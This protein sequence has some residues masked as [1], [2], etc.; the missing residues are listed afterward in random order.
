MQR[1][2]HAA[3]LAAVTLVGLLSCTPRRTGSG[4]DPFAGGASRSRSGVRE[5]RVR[6]EVNC[7]GCRIQ[8]WVGPGAADAGAD[9]LWSQQFT[10]TPLQPT[11][12]RVLATPREGGGTVRY[13]RIFV[14]GEIVAERGCPDCRDATAEVLT[15]DRGTVAAEVVVP[16]P[17]GS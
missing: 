9:Q 3:A 10:L 4:S 7:D 1:R 14:D 15:T 13:V 16:L 11:P 8:Y 17:E 6:L 5:Y 12:V 2:I